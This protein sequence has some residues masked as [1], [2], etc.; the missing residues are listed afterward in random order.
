MTYYQNPDHLDE[1][2]FAALSD[3]EISNLEIADHWLERLYDEMLDKIYGEIEVAGYTYMTSRTLY[4]IDPT[5]YRT[6]FSDWL[7]S[8]IQDGNI[9]EL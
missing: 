7:D 5:A 9:V 4:E 1:D 6:G 8:E 2:E 3:E